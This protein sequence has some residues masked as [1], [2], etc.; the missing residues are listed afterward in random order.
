MSEGLANIPIGYTIP[1]ES[2]SCILYIVLLEK[3]YMNWKKLLFMAALTGAQCLYFMKAGGILFDYV[4]MAA[5]SVPYL[6]M[7]G[8]FA[9]CCRMEYKKLV[10]YSIRAFI[11]AEFLA[12]LNWYLYLWKW[13]ELFGKHGEYFCLAAVYGAVLLIAYQVEEYACAES[14]SIQITNTALFFAALTGMVLYVASGWQIGVRRSEVTGEYGMAL[15]GMR[16]MVDFVGVIML[17]AYHMQL[18]KAYLD[19]ELFAVKAI[20]KKQTQQY[21]MSQECIDVINF[22]YHD[23]KHQISL[24]KK[25]TENKHQENYLDELQ[26]MIKLYEIRMHT[27]NEVLDTILAEKGVVCVRKE[28]RITNVADGKAL[29]FMELEDI[30]AVFGNALDNAIEYLEQVRDKEKRLIRVVVRRIHDFVMIQIE[31][32]CENE[33]CLEGRLPGSSKG[34]ERFH[35]YGLRSIRYISE[36]Y[37]G[38]MD[39]S[40]KE[41]WF[42]LKII[43]PFGR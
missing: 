36:K 11:L 34:D 31:N 32:Y 19:H 3:K 7:L 40:Q 5:M 13:K 17:S 43:L 16:T 21:E 12:S 2:L 37:H 26:K 22:K 18:C 9:L 38:K 8:C 14:G 6:L 10:Y 41:N 25:E 24:W 20:L 39:I 15:F 23:L 30:C 28:I 1:A 29:D 33:V 42:V 35:G 27:G 4:G